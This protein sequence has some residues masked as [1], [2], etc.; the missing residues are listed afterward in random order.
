MR[1]VLQDK[2]P[3]D[4]DIATNATPE[5]MVELCKEAEV[6]HILTGIN[7]IFRLNKSSDPKYIL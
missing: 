3:K 5:Q 2:P 1:D 6:K 4:I 7:C